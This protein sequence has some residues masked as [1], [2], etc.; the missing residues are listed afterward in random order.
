MAAFNLI[1]APTQASPVTLEE[2]KA[3]LRVAIDDDDGLI[4]AYLEAATERVELETGRQLL[5]AVRELW[6]D[7]AP[8][9]GMGLGDP[10][11]STWGPW[12]GSAG[13]NAWIDWGLWW[14]RRYIDMPFPPL[15]SVTSVKYVDTT[16]VTQTWDPTLY[17]VSAPSGPR[18]ERGRVQPAYGQ[19]WPVTRDQMD[20]V[21]VRFT[22]G[23]GADGDTVP[24]M[25]RRAILL[26]AGDWYQSREGTIVSDTRM[27]V[28]EL[29]YGV[30]NILQQYR[31]RPVLRAA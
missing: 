10:Q 13:L 7:S 8:G 30:N 26:I 23:Y 16:G 24:Q 6:L 3:H 4:Q 22:C 15:V 11:S 28:E 19:A 1:T 12:N 5:T 9:L 21:I 31:A 27:T 18:A 14:N 2:A 17:Q 25:L 29:P 20:A